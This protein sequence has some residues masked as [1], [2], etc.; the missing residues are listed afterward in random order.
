MVKNGSKSRSVTKSQEI[1]GQTKSN[2]FKPT[3]P[4]KN[5]WTNSTYYYETS[6]WLVF[7]RVLEEI[8]D[9]KKTFRN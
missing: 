8:E 4:P 6:V 2:F 5:E 1:K 9:T 7:V 3:F